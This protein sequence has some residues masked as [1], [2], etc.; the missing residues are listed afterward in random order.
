[1]EGTTFTA[2]TDAEGKYSLNYV[3]GKVKVLIR[4]EGYTSVSLTF[5]IAIETTFPAQQV[6]LYKVP[7]S[8]GIWL[9]GKSDY[10]P[11]K[12]GE[13]SFKSKEFPFSWDKPLF[14]ET[15]TT[16]EEFTS[17]EKDTTLRF[18]DN[19]PFKIVL[20]KLSGDN[21]ILSRIKYLTKKE[22]KF[23]RTDEKISEIVEGIRLREVS[24]DEGKYAFVRLGAAAE[25]G[26]DEIGSGQ[27]APGALGHPITEPVFLFEVYEIESLIKQLEDKDKLVR[28]HAAE[29]LGWIGL[30]QTLG[31]PAAV[32]TLIKALKDVD[33]EVR[34]AAASARREDW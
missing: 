8:Q 19:N 3:P 27:P 17:V 28:R 30:Y 25:I 21:V 29:A 2:K 5:D 11:L 6:T 34:A 9:I 20:A 13:I 10:V 16:V 1:M 7:P 12:K 15:Y 4:K 18:L 23:N 14:E 33:E 22:D 26:L 24:I 31:N 32:P